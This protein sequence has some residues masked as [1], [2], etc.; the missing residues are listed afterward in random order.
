MKPEAIYRVALARDPARYRRVG[1]DNMNR[2]LQS[3]SVVLEGA[4]GD[5]DANTVTYWY[6][7]AI[8]GLD[9]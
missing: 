1:E 5:E 3:G 2:L 9:R 7:R 6:R 8:A 4:D